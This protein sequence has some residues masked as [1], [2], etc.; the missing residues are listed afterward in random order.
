[1]QISVT[2]RRVEPSENLKQYAI[3]KISRVQKY[4]DTPAEAH[5][6]LSV[7]K[8]RHIAD[9]TINANGVNINGVEET[10]DLYSAIDMVVDK[11]ETQIKKHKNKFRRRKGAATR[12]KE[13]ESMQES[14]FPE[15][16]EPRIIKSEKFYAKP[17]DIDEAVMQLEL[18]DDTFLVFTNARTNNINVIYKR[19]DGN[20]GLIEPS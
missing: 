18:S 17:M 3:D 6:V 14:D 7:E 8:F 15:D 12:G 11:L 1:M 20:Y 10:E 4:L 16:S 2:F 13:L 9:V 5:V 19:K